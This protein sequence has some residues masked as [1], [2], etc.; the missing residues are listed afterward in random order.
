MNEQNINFWIPAV[1]W[2]NMEQLYKNRM[3]ANIS[4]YYKASRS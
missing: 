2:W 3:T 1:F 4:N